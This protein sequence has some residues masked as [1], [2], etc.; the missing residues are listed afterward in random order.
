MGQS[1]HPHSHLQPEA[2]DALRNSL[3][4]SSLQMTRVIKQ[5]CYLLCK[6]CSQ[7][8][9]YTYEHKSLLFSSLPIILGLMAQ[10]SL[11]DQGD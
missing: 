1:I 3:V 4:A 8:L 7:S 5:G 2:M 9:E 11:K 6:V 10:G